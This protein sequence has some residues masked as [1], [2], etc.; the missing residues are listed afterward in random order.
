M[1]AGGGVPGQSVEVAG[2]IH[3]L[4]TTGQRAVARLVDGL[5]AVVVVGVLYGLA[6]VTVLS[7][8]TTDAAG[9]TQPS[10][11]GIAVA[12]VIMG[13]LFVFGV[14]YEVAF[15][16]TSG[17]TPG[18]KL[19]HIKVVRSF[20]GQIPG[21]GPATVRW[22]VP[23]GA[24]ILCGALQLLVYLSFLFDGVRKQGWH[25]KAASTYVVAS[26]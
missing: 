21:W 26:A 17:A 23:F 5:I 11:A 20:D 4:A 6:V 2:R 25:D 10:G 7:T 16:A 24:G 12:L 8:S 3:T 18:K 22:V 9:G 13:S 19:A 14:L 1:T 15:V